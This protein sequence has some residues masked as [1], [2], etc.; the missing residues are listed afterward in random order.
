MKQEEE[1]GLQIDKLFNGN[2]AFRK[3][4]N[5]S[6]SL[7]ESSMLDACGDKNIKVAI[8]LSFTEQ[9][10]IAQVLEI[11]TRDTQQMWFV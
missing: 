6:L 3:G 7:F 11:D 2:R 8:A 5:T 9:H 10:V 1:H 4:Q